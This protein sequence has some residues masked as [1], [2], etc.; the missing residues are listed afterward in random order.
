MTTPPQLPITVKGSSGA[1]VTFDGWTVTVHHRSGLGD[2]SVPIGQLAGVEFRKAGL[3]SAGMFT[4]L[5]AGTVAPKRRPGLANRNPLAV[6]L[7]IGSN[8]EF[9]A[10]RDVI[11]R[12]VAA[13]QAGPRQ[14]AAAPPS[15]AD[16]L[17]RLGQMVQQGLLTPAQ[18]EQA[19][20]QLLGGQR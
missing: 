13:Q 3:L 9:A 12:A 10:L 8:R 18:F 19:K 2:A 6:W 5:T 16:E 20:Q 4:L 17:A 1:S 15:L 14:Y 7:T 11:L